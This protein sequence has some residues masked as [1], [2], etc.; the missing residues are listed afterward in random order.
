MRQLL[1]KP[2]L[3]ILILMTS[4]GPFGDTEYAPSLPHMAKTLQTSYTA[5]Q[6]TMTVY[7]AA[8]AFM[9]LFY[10]PLSD[11]F[12][13]KPIVLGGAGL[14]TLGSFI[15][16]VSF[17]L[18]LLLFG[19]FLQGLGA[20]AGA[21]I[22][23]AA[24]RDSFPKETIDTVYAKINAA[25]ALSPAA[26]PIVGA[27]VADRF[28]WHANM[29]ILFVLG[30]FLIAALAL[31]FPETHLPDKSRR[32]NVADLFLTYQTLFRQKKFLPSVF[33]NA[34]AIGAVY[35]SLTE[36]PALVT[37][38]FGLTSKWFA[39]V[40]F[41]V[42]T[43]FSLGSFLSIWLERSL[44]PQRIIP[45]GL[46]C[47]FAGGAWLS[48]L[49]FIHIFTLATVMPAI[50]LAYVGIAL[51]VPNAMAVAMRPFSAI[52]GAASAMAGF[53][54]MFI[55]SVAIAGTSLLPNGPVYALGVAFSILGLLGFAAFR[56][57][58]RK[59]AEAG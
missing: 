46:I 9:Q 15:C 31:Y 21:I 34:V 17:S 24:V 13:R 48:V 20:C 53:V 51:V 47:I 11:R 50:M 5:V 49:W 12:G 54:Q 57:G 8:Y 25:F 40:A 59:R 32:L 16:Y 3:W 33:I 44:H 18:D 29:L 56:L 1:R 52:A 55:A 58:F 28:G 42:L 27:F 41:L 19:R 30:I 45:W 14:F 4:V 10:G 35:T 36:G 22:S 2:S 38:T 6:Q 37:E 23:S 39:L 43:A 7:L 26:G